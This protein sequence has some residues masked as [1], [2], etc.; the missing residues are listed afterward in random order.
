MFI[1]FVVSKSTQSITVPL[2]K[3]QTWPSDTEID[4][5]TIFWLFPVSYPRV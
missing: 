1:A 4:F 5:D 3:V 2:K